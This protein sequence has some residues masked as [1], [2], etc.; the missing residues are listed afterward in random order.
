VE[1]RNA[2]KSVLGTG[3]R[4]ITESFPKTRGGRLLINTQRGQHIT[5]KNP[6]CVATARGASVSRPGEEMRAWVLN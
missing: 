3:A 4:R 5:T 6:G 2:K 1:W